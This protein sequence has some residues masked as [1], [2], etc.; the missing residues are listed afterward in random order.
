[1]GTRGLK[2]FVALA[3]VAAVAP[4]TALAAPPTPQPYGAHDSGGFRNILPP[5]ENGLANAAQIAAFEL[6]HTYP[7]HANDQ[8]G[9]YAN[10]LYGSPGLTTAQIGELLQGR[11]I[12][13]EA[14]R[15]R[16][17]L[18]P[19]RRRHDR[20]RPIRRSAHLRRDPRRDDVRGGLRRR[21]GPPVLHRRAAE[22]RAA[23]NSRPSRAAPTSPWT[24]R[25]WADTPYNEADLQKQYDQ[26]DDVYGVPGQAHPERRPELRRGDQ[27]VHR[28]G[29]RQPAEDAGRVRVDRQAASIRAP[30]RFR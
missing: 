25:V 16:A 30:T 29:V 28:R 14:R 22:T 10:L 6:N 27:P 2:S 15:R 24:S 18:Q 7:P 12:R 9:M 19:A 23:P 17:H 8:L 4:A 3:L 20:A 13:R 26:A 1:M 5:G 21:R 11:H